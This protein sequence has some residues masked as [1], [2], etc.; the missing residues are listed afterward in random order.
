M[1][2]QTDGLGLIISSGAIAQLN[3]H[4]KGSIYFFFFALLL[5]LTLL[6][7]CDL[8]TFLVAALDL[9]ADG[10]ALVLRLLFPKARSQPSAYFWF[11]PAREIVIPLDSYH[12][13]LTGATT[14]VPRRPVENPQRFGFSRRPP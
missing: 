4:Q 10:L 13:I 5:F 1:G 14:A 11:E 3:L 6:D 8:A 12:K 2:R 9:L 7:F